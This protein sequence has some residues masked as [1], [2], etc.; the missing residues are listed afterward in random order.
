MIGLLGGMFDPVHNG[1]IQ[2]AESARRRLDLSAVRFIP[3]H[4]PSHRPAPVAS[5]HHRCAMVCVALDG[6]EGMVLDDREVRRPA[7]S[8]TVDTLRELRAELGPDQPLCLLLGGDAY[9]HLPTW[10]EWRDIPK[11]ARV[12]VIPRTEAPDSS[13]RSK[14]ISSAAALEIN[15][16]FIDAD[17]PA[18]SSEQIRTALKHGDTIA[19]ALPPAVSDYIALHR[20]YN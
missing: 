19:G 10:K 6:C 14:E 15:A 9:A 4:I 13:R 1:H 5:A 2:L 16:T 12:A 11:L 8:Y 3:C 20:L 18:C 17:V 7:T